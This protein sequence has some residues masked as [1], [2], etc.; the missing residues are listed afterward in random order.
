MKAGARRDVDIEVGVVH[1]MQPPQQRHRVKHDVLEIDRK[2]ER[3]QGQ[4]HLEP[5][6]QLKRMQ[7]PHAARFREQRDSHRR[8]G[9]D[10]PDQ[11]RVND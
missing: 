4:Q 8:G 2:I 7:Q 9:K 6:A 10:R 5:Q 1:A 11:R 3:N